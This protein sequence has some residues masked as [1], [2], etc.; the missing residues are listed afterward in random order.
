MRYV[1]GGYAMKMRLSHILLLVM[2]AVAVFFLGCPGYDGEYSLT[3]SYFH[4]DDIIGEWVS[5]QP[6]NASS[7]SKPMRIKIFRNSGDKYYLF[8]I[9]DSDKNVYAGEYQKF[10]LT[11]YGFD[12]IIEK[13]TSVINYIKFEFV[14]DNRFKIKWFDEAF[15]KDQEF[16]SKEAF[17]KFVR[18]HYWKSA[19]WDDTEIEFVRMSSSY[20]SRCSTCRGSGRIVCPTCH[21]ERRV[22]ALS[23]F[24][25]YRDCSRC[26]E[27][28]FFGGSSG[29]TGEIDC[30][31]CDGTGKR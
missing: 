24:S 16:K 1:S 3:D 31:D 5:V 8:D 26:T 29:P 7:D 21:G 30:P 27:S 2:L 15:F 20:V 17:R 14:N 9:F 19:F 25:N 18:T 4:D 10:Y 23:A 22:E 13:Y 12:T 28:S 6:S 11:K